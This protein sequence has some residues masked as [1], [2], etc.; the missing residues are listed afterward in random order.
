M[1]PNNTPLLRLG[2]LT[3]LVVAVAACSSNNPADTTAKITPKRTTAPPAAASKTTTPT[4]TASKAG[5]S[6][7]GTPTDNASSAT[8]G[9]TSSTAPSAGTS[10]APSTAASSDSSATS[11]SSPGA[12]PSVSPSTGSAS[13]SASP[14]S[15]TIPASVAPS[16]GGSSPSPS[17]SSVSPSPSPSPAGSPS[18]SSSPTATPTPAASP[19]TT[20]TGN[21]TT[22]AGNGLSGTFNSNASNATFTAP[23]AIAA[24]GS[25]ALYVADQSA[26]QV[27][28]IDLSASGN[29][30][31]T[32]AGSG[33][34]GSHNGLGAGATFNS[35]GG[36][37]VDGS[38]NVYVADTGN[39]EIRKIDLSDP[40]NPQVST[41]AGQAG[42]PGSDNGPGSVA[43]FHSPEG[44][45]ISGTTLFVA[46][47]GNHEIR[48]IDLSDANFGVT[49]TV[50][51]GTPGTSDG[52]S[53]IAQ[54]QSPTGVTVDSQGNLYVTDMAANTI[55][56]V[57]MS[58][59]NHAVS[60]IA[61]V[62]AVGH[63]D[64]PGSGAAFHS[65]TSAV[66]G[67]DGALYVADSG[68]DDIRRIDLSTTS[69]T[70]STYA[71]AGSAGFL[72]AMG[73]SAMFSG[74]SGLASVGGTLYV[75]DPGNFRVR[76]IQ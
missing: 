25:T 17:P 76:M 44:L 56:Y 66:I 62:N 13:P 8:S 69:Y 60:T 12:S 61:G 20:G 18:P 63:T 38:G 26:N 58:D 24:Q 7:G 57:L 50:G 3:T 27:R 65:P 28:R 49:T 22:F 40:N 2:V 9:G 6:E 41:I 73:T 10:T 21:V 5:S 59:A 46:D 55:R 43:T 32:V 48:Q 52:P 71:G 67:S 74:P 54:F 42:V 30:V 31:T 19:G 36:I 35:L 75:A 29:P 37:A 45:A 53:S 64:G 47:K 23:F 39:Q 15:S 16:G 51:T 34:S 1:K 4:S 11:A 33:N 68:N 72:D 14:S 70:V